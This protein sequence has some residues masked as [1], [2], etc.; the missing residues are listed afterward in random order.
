[1]T[2]PVRR[3]GVPRQVP[4]LGW[5][6]GRESDPL[7]RLVG[8]LI[9]DAASETPTGPGGTPMDLEE[10]G[11]AYLLEMDLPGVSKDAVNVEV[12]DHEIRVSGE[13]KQ[14]E[15]RGRLHHQ[16]RPWGQFDQV[17]TLPGEVD[18]GQAE[19]SL[20]DGVLT[21]RAPK[22]EAA[23]PRKVEVTVS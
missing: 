14:R 21:V 8:H 3:S 19:A 23:K 18:P 17:V 15:D 1:M 4:R 22:A 20:A 16:T 11:D 2:M 7:Y 10:T 13:A 12:T 9:Q 6:W 5:A